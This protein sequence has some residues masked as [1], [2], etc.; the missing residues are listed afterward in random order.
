MKKTKM[1]CTLGPASD[2]KEILT[3]MIQ[4]GL[5]VA[6]L[7]FSHGSHEEHAGRIQR[8][9]EVRKELN[10]PVALMLDTKG[11]EIRTGDLKEGKVTLE[12]G[13]KI[14]LT[15]EQIE[16]DADR[17]SV[18]YEGL[19]DDLSVGNKIL[20]DDGLI[21]LNVDRID[22]TEIYCSIDNGGVLGSK[23]S[24]NI[25][26]VE[27]NLPGLTPKDESDL[28][29]GIKQKVDFVAA[30]FV[31]KP[32][33][34]IAIRKVLENNGGG[35]IQIISKIENREG[36]EKIDR[37]LAVSDGIMVAR[38]DLGVEIPAEEVPLVQKS[39]IKKC[40]LLGKPVITATQMLDSMIRNPRPTR[41]EVGD[42]A[43]AVFDGTDAVM[44]SGE[45]AAGA[46]PVQAVETM[47]NIVEKTERSEE[48]IN[49][50]KPEHGELTI[51]NAVSEAAVQIAANLDATAIIAATSSGHTPRMLSKYRPECTIL[52]VSDK[53]STV[54][55]LTLSW[56]VYCMYMTELR[57]TDSMVHDSVQ[58][59][60]ELGVVKIGDLAVVAAGVPLGVQGNTNMIKVHTVGN[61]IMS[62]IGIGD[63]PVTGYAKLINEDNASE[64][65]EGDILVVKSLSPDISWILDKA[66]AIITEEG[67]LSSEGAI[68][69]LHYNIPVI[70]G[71]EKALEIIGHG[72]LISVDP[73][74]GMVYQG[75]VRMV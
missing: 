8:I 72:K 50:Q 25:P 60:V 5:N 69:G 57:D 7:N 33:D 68:A 16:G 39:I 29:F 51:T 67:G 36:V 70:V 56:G 64:F 26:N 30:S 40:N 2:S 1:V 65:K 21:E 22:G 18:S 38:G 48:Y 59:A 44:L 37:I 35:N 28:I 66:A 54:R 32:Q 55:R 20:I 62:G 17:V 49:R 24:V 53:V 14:V 47:A 41:A 58:A 12:T 6:R 4:G 71:V 13:K 74:R 43:N 15:S 23:K 46:Y 3:K 34:V 45:T 10:I 9:K 27:I 63:K 52:A 73:K 11:P 61:A 31:R 75:K 19:P 42:V